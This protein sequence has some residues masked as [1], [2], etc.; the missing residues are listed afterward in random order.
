MNNRT[1]YTMVGFQAGI[2]AFALILLQLLPQANTQLDKLGPMAWLWGLVAA[3]LS[4]IVLAGINRYSQ[5]MQRNT[6]ATLGRMR[7][8]F[9]PL[10]LWQLIAI[11]MLAGVGE[12]LLFRAFLQP[13]IGA[14]SHVWIGIALASIIFA[15]MHFMSWL[16]FILTLI[17]GLL[18]GVGYYLSQ[19]LVFVIVWH[20]TYDLIALWVLV[21]APHLLGLSAKP[22]VT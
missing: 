15:L 5:T 22:R 1:F 12:E 16:Y 19:S 14:Y 3:L 20:S 17:M 18:L 6:K 4:Y 11:S 21:H 2:T 13:F 7:P 10:A 8:L 9:T